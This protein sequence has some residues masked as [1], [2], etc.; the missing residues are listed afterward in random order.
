[1]T[2]RSTPIFW[3][4]SRF[5]QVE[6]R[7]VQDGRKVCYAPHSHTQWSIGAITGGNSLFVYQ[8]QTYA[9]SEG[10]LVLMNPN[11]VHACNPVADQPWSYF[12]LYVD[13]PWLTRL[14]CDAG[15]LGET[16]WQDLSTALIT[17]PVWYDRYCRMAS[18]LLDSETPL[19][20]KRIAVT[21]FLAA[22]MHK[23][24]A[25][26]ADILTIP[27]KLQAVADYLQ[28]HAMND[29]SLETLCAQSGYSPG[30]LIKAFR[31]CFGFTPHAYL[32]NLR[33]QRGQAA[34]KRGAAIADSA[35]QA[36]FADQPHFQRTFKRL[37]ATTPGQYKQPSP[38]KQIPATGDQ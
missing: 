12:M 13:T 4:D 9:V 8:N 29:I 30:H 35:L 15:L 11:K 38:D 17:E 10:T 34:L 5:P 33:V 26:P 32:I 6:L 37:L 18:N 36:G 28:E 2:E 3:R 7:Q 16:V 22:L 21:D 25:Q 14:R 20:E 23:T 27:S 31:D 24:A 1:M 19:A